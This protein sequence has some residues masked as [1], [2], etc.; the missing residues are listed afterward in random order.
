MSTDSTEKQA[1][2]PH[3]EG[4]PAQPNGLPEMVSEAD[5]PEAVAAPVSREDAP[6]EGVEQSVRNREDEILERYR[7]AQAAGEAL[8]IELQRLCD[9]NFLGR[10]F[11]GLDLSGC[12]FTGSELSRCNFKGAVA[13]HAKFDRATLFQACLDG[14]EFM[15]SSF[16]EANLSEATAQGAG[17]GE[18]VFDGANLIR[19]NLD[20]ASAI[21][22]SWSKARVHLAS[23]QDA[24]LL[25]SRMHETE[26]N[27]ANLTGSDLRECDVS[28]AD[29]GKAD[30][31]A[32]Q[33]R[34]LRNYTSANWIGSDIRDIDFTGAYLVRRHIVDENYLEEFRNQ[35]RMARVIYWL[36]WL[37]S[38]CGR[39]LFRWV[40]LN[41]ILIGLFAVVFAVLPSS[42][43][44]IDPD[45]PMKSAGFATPLTAGT[46][47]I[48]GTAIAYDP[49]K[50]SLN[51]LC[52]RIN[53]KTHQTVTAAYL[54]KEDVLALWSTHGALDLKDQDGGNLIVAT[55]VEATQSAGWR[56]TTPLGVVTPAL[57][58]PSD[59]QRS[60]YET[61]YFSFV[62]ALTLGFGD[63]LPKTALAQFTVN[64]LTLVGYV[65]LGGLLTIF[66]NQLGRRGE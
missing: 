16:R 23:I 50:D 25:E 29:F 31:H 32:I 35:G 60:W 3:A 52:E 44:K 43:A 63:I 66:S 18:A 37:T 1:P 59:L 28:G 17:F 61:L 65:G 10:D 5:A 4:G 2:D 12:D 47:K 22:S 26:F 64:L 6:P 13:T 30:L 9:M 36:W 41:F 49:D 33:L 38:D 53:S 14:G 42:L 62:V 21:K 45:A 51:Q 54:Q 55:H 40:V 8:P 46:L 34:G 7:Q 48:D 27:Q 56:S 11:S 19:T 24:R 15:A 39:S 58:V 57:Y 20:G